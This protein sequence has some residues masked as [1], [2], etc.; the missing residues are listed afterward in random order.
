MIYV[1]YPIRALW[2]CIVGLDVKGHIDTLHRLYTTQ[3][4]LVFHVKPHNG[5][6]SRPAGYHRCN[7]CCVA[8]PDA[9]ATATNF[10]RH[11]IV[12]VVRLDSNHSSIRRS[13]CHHHRHV[14]GRHLCWLQCCPLRP[15][16]ASLQRCDSHALWCGRE[17]IHP[18]ALW[19]TWRQLVS[20]TITTTPDVFEHH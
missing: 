16:F 7:R 14:R 18:H 11:A 1:I 19:L 4:C 9:T 15:I 12:R 5:T 20:C 3:S 2:V 10:S 8:S 6:P 17:I 13:L